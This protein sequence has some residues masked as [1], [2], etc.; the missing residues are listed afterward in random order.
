MTNFGKCSF[1]PNISENPRVFVE[2]YTKASP[3]RLTTYQ[4][5]WFRL[6]YFL[7]DFPFLYTRLHILVQYYQHTMRKKKI[8][9]GTS[10]TQLLKSQ[11]PVVLRNITNLGIFQRNVTQEETVF[12][13]SCFFI[14]S[15]D[16]R[17][18]YF[19][20]S[21]RWS[22]NWFPKLLRQSKLHVQLNITCLL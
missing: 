9:T 19:Q 15:Y 10:N 3:R 2:H 12:T 6:L 20:Q 14:S 17:A 21:R 11:F 8:K 13:R 22:F 4:F 5:V 7:Q 16:K 1:S 18:F